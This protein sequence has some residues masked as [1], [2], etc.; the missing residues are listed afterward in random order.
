MAKKK[1]TVKPQRELTKR[2]LSHWQQQKRRQRIIFNA[3]IITITVAVV[4]M[5]LGWYFGQYKP[6]HQTVIR[7]N[8]T[9]F[10]MKY[11]IDMLELRGEG[12]S[13]EY[14]HLLADDVVEEIERI[15]L[16]RQGA[17]KLGVNASEE[18]VEEELKSSGLPAKDAAR[19]LARSR[20]LLEKLQNEYFASQIPTSFEQANILAMLLESEKQAVEVRTRLEN[21]ESF[22]ELAGELSLEYFTKTDEGD[23]GW[24]P[25]S[26]FADLLGTSIPTEYAFGAEAG[27]LSQPIYDEELVKNVGYWLTKVLERGEEEEEEAHVHAMLL[28]SE[29]EAQDIIARLETGD[30]FTTLAKEFSQLN[31]AETN[32]GDLGIVIKGEM[33]TAFDEFVFNLDIEP[34][35]LSE[36]IRDETIATKGGYWLVK[37]V[38]KDDDRQLEDSDR[39]LLKAKALEEWGFSLLDD[40]SNEIDDSYL[41]D[42]KKEWAIEQAVRAISTQGSRGDEKG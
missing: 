31:G 11:Y 10:D 22:A 39:N 40:P 7:V 27:K 35:T 13:I 41:D 32:E 3:G 28:G 26:I 30:N 18:E 21:N 8:S 16:I 33:T 1:K 17:S 14:I 4:L 36:S 25:E 29:T 5:L 15:E 6:L 19:D 9:E 38:D 34:G 23:L 20:I 37:V 2:Q 24:H 12:Q 42:E